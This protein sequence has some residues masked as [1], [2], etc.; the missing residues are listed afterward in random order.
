M[1]V[2]HIPDEHRTIR[3]KAEIAAYLNNIGI[4][5]EDVGQLLS[6]LMLPKIFHPCSAVVHIFAIAPHAD[7][8]QVR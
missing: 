6:P 4:D 7:K 1:A 2:L 5:Y 3:D 8:S